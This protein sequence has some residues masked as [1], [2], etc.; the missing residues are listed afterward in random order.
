M[1]TFVILTRRA[2]GAAEDF[3]RLA[4][5]EAQHVW[6]GFADGIVRAVHGLA[7]GPGA[8]FELE[9]TTFV[10]ARQYIEALPYVSENLLHVQYCA[11]KP[12]SDYEK[13]V[14]S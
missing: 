11:L 12:F 1:K 6:K 14:S 7:D 4:K 8:A 3:K 9:S 2:D 13:L 10:E 5:P